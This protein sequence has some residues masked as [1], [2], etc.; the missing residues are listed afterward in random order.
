MLSTQVV[1]AKCTGTGVSEC[2]TFTN[3]FKDQ[4]KQCES[5]YKKGKLYGGYPCKWMADGL[6]G[7]CTPL[8]ICN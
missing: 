2:D 3:A 5:S 7:K 8:G 1:Q 4:S 6:G